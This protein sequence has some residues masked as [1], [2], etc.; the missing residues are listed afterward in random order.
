[1]SNS[2]ISNRK[3]RLVI[4]VEAQPPKALR[5][6]REGG[7]WGAK[8]AIEQLAPDL[9]KRFKESATPPP[10]IA[11]RQLSNAP[12]QDFCGNLMPQSCLLLRGYRIDVVILPKSN[13]DC[14]CG[15]PY[16]RRAG[17]API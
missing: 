4:C 9:M 6:N 15:A 1:M 17:A 5:L 16:F 2:A 13:S 12:S 3:K 8:S 7:G 10:K 14:A 11:R